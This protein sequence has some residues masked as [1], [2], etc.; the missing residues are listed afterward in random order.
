[1]QEQDPMT[2][3]AR[4]TRLEQQVRRTHAELNRQNARSQVVEGDFARDRLRGVYPSRISSL[5]ISAL[6]GERTRRDWAENAVRAYTNAINLDP[7]LPDAYVGRASV[8]RFLARYAEAKQDLDKARELGVV[9]IPDDKIE[10]PHRIRSRR[11]VLTSAAAGAIAVCSVAVVYQQWSSR[12]STSV[13][14]SPTELPA[15]KSISDSPN[16]APLPKLAPAKQ[17]ISP[18]TRPTAKLEHPQVTVKATAVPQPMTPLALSGKSTCPGQPASDGDCNRVTSE[19][20]ALATPGDPADTARVRTSSIPGARDPQTIPELAA[21]K[22]EDAEMIALACRASDA[23]GT[24]EYQSC[25]ASQ[26]TSLEQ[27]IPMP[28]LSELAPIDRQ[29]VRRTCS[30]TTQ[31][32]PAAYRRCVSSQ[33]I[34]LAGAPELPDLTSFSAERKRAMDSACNKSAAVGAAAY[35]NCMARQAKPARPGSAPAPVTKN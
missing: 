33:L 35:H 1:M 20:S 15:E 12:Q 13:D 17:L 6:T 8:Y 16:A 30:N 26:L 31:D 9:D 27:A 10:P 21:V 28:D 19:S 7:A 23:S 22:R 29:L 34:S 5:L 14:S 4:G 11:I 18:P 32:G 3:E 2:S 25:I 24:D